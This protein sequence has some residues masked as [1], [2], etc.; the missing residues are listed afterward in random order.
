M[1][2]LFCYTNK[3]TTCVILNKMLLLKFRSVQ[4]SKNQTNTPRLSSWLANYFCTYTQVR[5][6]NGPKSPQ[7]AAEASA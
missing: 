2:Q 7:F 5:L 1:D 3:N 6:K 4:N